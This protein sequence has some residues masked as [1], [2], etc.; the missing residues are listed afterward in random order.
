MIASPEKILPFKLKHD[1]KIVI[2]EG[3]SRKETSWKNKEVEWGQLVAR[4]SVTRRTGE[5]MD[6]YRKMAKSQQDEI[7]DVG[8]FV[9]GTLKG[10]RRKSDAVGWRQI[11]SLDA[12]HAPKSFWDR[13]ELLTDFGMAVYSTHKHKPEA[14]RLR[15]L[16]PLARTVT[17]DE[18]Q[19]VSRR[20]AADFGIDNFDDTTFEPSRLM[21]WPSTSSDGEFFFQVIDE[22][23]IDPDKILARFHDWR[24]PSEWPESSRTTQ[25]RK[26]LADKQGDP[27]EKPGIVGA[28][29]RV[30]SIDEAIEKYL[31][32]IYTP[33]D[34]PDRYTYI[35]GS[36]AGGL[37]L[38]EHH[39][40]FSHHGTDPIS[41]KLCNAFDLV[42]IHKF[43]DLD[44]E[45]KP[46]TPTVKLPSYTAMIELSTGD[47]VVRTRLGEERLATALEEFED[48]GDEE[49]ETPK[50]S[51][52]VAK[53]KI[54]SKG[55][56]ESSIDNVRIILERD[57][58]L[59][60][61][62]GFDEFYLRPVV[63]GKVPWREKSDPSPW[64]DG[65]DSGL[66]HYV[67]K[68][69][70]IVTPN[71][72][73]DA[74]NLV[75]GKVKF[76]PVREYLN[77]LQWDGEKRLDSLFIDYLGAE[78]CE[79]IR[80]VTRK[81][82]VAAV[83]RVMNPGVKF[84]YM[85]TLVG[86]QGTWK[87]TILNKL[88]RGWYSDSLYTV[89][90]KEAYEQLI[91]QWIMEIAEMNATKKAD[92]DAIKHFITKQEDIF[93]L[94]YARR[95]AVVKRQN[96]FIGTTNDREFLRDKTGNRRFWP[97]LIRIA[98]PTKS[99][100]VDL[101]SD[102]I[103][104]IWAE[105]VEF[106][107][108]GEVLYLTPEMEKEA[109]RRQDLHTEDNAKA[110][111]IQEF[112]EKKLP[113]DWDS[114]DIL[115]RK[116]WF[117]NEFDGE[118]GSVIRDKVCAAEIWVECFGG[119][120]KNFGPIQSREIGDILRRLDGWTPYSSSRGRM[121]FSNYGIQRA[122]VRKSDIFE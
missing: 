67:E 51:S 113:E 35:E 38:Y 9:G 112:L 4:I 76:H 6:E 109:V 12:D 105:A 56:F 84:D 86:P 3:R 64:N 39:F 10:G 53:L 106:W 103:D 29:C 45:A 58:R 49:E 115:S 101:T 69:F 90:G 104:Q 23:W 60:G 65:D 5:T 114:R 25:E 8:G 40:A 119:E 118:E 61:K 120:F 78:D 94:P 74:V 7:K 107:K 73:D 32:D 98:E 89:Q 66:R 82:L 42:R 48:L 21:Y 50:D 81:C 46:G 11:V 31:P 27:T 52:W 117:L 33:C 102:E 17:A 77:G 91:G 37:V 93:R 68:V 30:Y 24:D 13:I 71:K 20:I 116:T 18:Y 36:T 100:G 111:V 55:K 88:G 2:A 63:I 108:D 1:G 72:I 96:I 44:D 41:G 14:P 85:L 57:P 34:V 110:G 87:S 99:V 122:Y 54:D 19:A 47:E 22:P 75:M 80:T 28:F 92:V 121:R 26:K 43:G 59:V 16:I 15:L 95:A 70:E 62:I 83:A 97:V 79:Y